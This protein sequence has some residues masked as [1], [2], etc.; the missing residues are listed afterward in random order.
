MSIKI[1][2]LA[3]TLSILLLLVSVV[4]VVSVNKSTDSMLEADFEKL[5]TVNVA[6]Y[7]EIGN[8]L[9]LLKGLLTSLA[10]QEGTK[11]AFLAFEDGFYDLDEELNLDI[12]KI[13]SAIYADMNSNYL[14]SVNYDVPHS[15]QK[16]PTN[17]YLPTDKNALIAQY[18]FIVDNKFPLG[19]KNSLTYN[20]KYDSKYMKAH[21]K[22]HSSFNAFL[23]AYSLYDIFMVDLKGNL[24]YTD[25]KE[26]DFATNLKNGIYSDT[27]IAQAYKKALNMKEGELAFDDFA[28]YEPSYNS[29]ASFIATPIFIDGVKKG[30]LIFQMPVDEINSIMRFKEKFEEAGLGESGECYLVGTDYM[31]RSNSRFQKDIENSVVKN[32][33]TTIGVWKVKTKTTQAVI[34][35]ASTKGSHIIDDYRD[36]SVLS[37]YNTLDIFGQAR[38]IVVAE[39]DEE[40]A[41]LPAVDLKYSIIIAS[42]I[43][44][45]LAVIILLFLIN[46][47]LVRPLRELEK[48]AEDLAHGDGDLTARLAIIGDDEISKISTFINAF[49]QKVQSTIIQAKTTSTQNFAVSEKLAS[50]SL[51]IETKVEEELALVA[52]VSVQGDEIQ[53]TLQTSIKNAEETRSEL[54]N[55]ELIL[56]KA[57]NLIVSLSDNI[58]IRSNEE[59]E[60]ANRLQ[61]LSSDTQEVKVVLNVISDIADQT[62][63][64][65]LNAAIEAARAGE[66]GRGFA[67][68]ADEVRKLAEGIQKSLSEINATINIMVQSVTDASDAISTNAL[69]IEKLSDDANTAQVEI[70]DSV[71]LMDTVVKKVDLMVNGYSSNGEAIQKMM[72]R[73]EIVHDVSA[74]NAKNV[75]EIA[76]ASEQLSS[77]TEKLNILL[78]SYKT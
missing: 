77:M 2:V 72:D 42:T 65:A 70:H 21:K 8:Y 33:G 69:E 4:I 62:N 63:L 53:N 78:S 73:V 67:V 40:E 68:V 28:P 58:G 7:D 54:N 12:S 5:S 17:D 47:A 41:L 25:F 18:I 50:T 24:I 27:G 55:A 16:K 36:I 38:W 23:K 9:N 13:K 48:R 34:D 52:E 31:M 56:G 14:N 1:K 10:T 20:K 76:S 37:V 6:K 59:T 46:F 49:I 15:Q 64:L 57:N 44:I 51:Q 66:H 26:K 19:E 32:L 22:Y 60:L 43:I 35:G 74:S 30:V 45:I 75:E 39:I 71:T 11:E 29:P 3:A 61:Q